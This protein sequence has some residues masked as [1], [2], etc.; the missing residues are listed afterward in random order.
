ML[1]TNYVQHKRPYRGISQRLNIGQE[2]A[3]DRGEDWIGICLPI[4]SW[5]GLLDPVFGGEKLSQDQRSWR[6]LLSF[7]FP[8]FHP[9]TGR[10]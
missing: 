1:Y 4:I 2:G 8:I 5:C 7:P 10:I 3:R 9:A 6:G